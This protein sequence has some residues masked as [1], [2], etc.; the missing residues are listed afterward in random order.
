MEPDQVRAQHAVE[1]L[2]LP[3]TNAESLRIRPG[4]VP[5]DRNARV[6]PAFLDQAR[7]Q[8][9]MIILDE[10]HRFL[11]TAHFV[12]QHSGEFPIHRLVVF[13]VLGAKN[14][15]RVRDV[16]ERPD[17]LVGEAEIEP[18]LFLFTEPDAAERVLGMIRRDAEAGFL[19]GGGASRIQAGRQVRHFAGQRLEDLFFGRLAAGGGVASPRSRN[20]C[21]M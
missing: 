11:F 10:H 18:L 21:A 15:P 3:R 16:A 12:Q 2:A 1:Q 17:S 14:G 6:G 7:Q 5:E 20:H 8:G 4:N 19:F 13:P 9:E